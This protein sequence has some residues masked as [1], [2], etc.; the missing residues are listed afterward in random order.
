MA[1]YFALVAVA[2]E[3]A[4]KANITGWKVGTAFNA[5]QQVFNQW[6][7]SF[8]QV[9]DFE[10]REILA[11]VKAFFEANESSR[12]ESIT[13]DPDHIERINNRVGYWKI[14]NGEKIFYVL[15]E[16]FK[17]EVCKGYDSRKAARALLAYNLLEHDTDKN[18]KTVRLP[19]RKNS[20]K[21]YAVK[22]AIFSW[23]V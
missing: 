23:E 17:N 18:Q 10:D 14:E 7:G 15:P 9:G 16:Q 1:N 20:V 12:F 13:P 22:E 11:H 4:T 6:L 19:S 8:E 2:G 3:L 21:V 5:V